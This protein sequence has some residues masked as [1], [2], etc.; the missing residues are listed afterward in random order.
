MQLDSKSVLKKATLTV[1]KRGVS[2]VQALHGDG[3]LNLKS[4]LR[5]RKS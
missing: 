5:Q 2:L 3:T 1:F 4:G